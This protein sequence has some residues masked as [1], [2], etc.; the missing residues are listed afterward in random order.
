M[1]SLTRDRNAPPLTR[2]ERPV[3]PRGRWEW[4]DPIEL[5]EAVTSAQTVA[6]TVPLAARWE[7]EPLPASWPPSPV[8]EAD[9]FDEYDVLPSAQFTPGPEYPAQQP[10]RAAPQIQ[11][12]P[13]QRQQPHPQQ[14]PQ[15]QPQRQPQ[16]QSQQHRASLTDTVMHFAQ[17]ASGSTA[18]HQDWA[19]LGPIPAEP[20]RSADPSPSRLSYRLNRLWLT[21]TVRHFV[22]VGLPIMLMVLF[23]GGWLADEGRR[24]SIVE[25][26]VSVRTAVENR[27]Q[28]QVTEITVDSRSPE[29][30]Q[31]VAQLLAISFPISSFQLD[32]PALRA[33]AEALDAVDRASLQVRS[34][35]LEVVIDE[36]LPA[37]VWRNGVGLDLIDGSG[38]RVARL[39]SRAARP[40]L[41]LIA[42]DGAPEAIAE[43]RL[44]W[45]AASPIR[46]RLRGLERVGERRWDVVLDRDQRI[47]LPAN[48]A[49][50]A[51]ER[52]MALNMAQDILARDVQIVDLRNPTRPTLRLSSEAMD[53][54]SRIR[55]ES[56]GAQNR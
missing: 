35:V 16:Q 26:V 27:P 29:V 38:H 15:R 32:L 11:P 53:E 39:A 41:P 20:Q 54:L 10:R 42:G 2:K 48:G 22:R 55:R 34:G 9:R 45:A 23:I 3:D 46:D 8:A 14:Q 19:T 40:D 37:M 51:L 49:L 47:M 52:V 12:R 4:P 44:L 7:C 1:S 43:A 18:I 56:S 36:R 17:S 5:P 33:T 13:V 28:F 30:A 50:G 25:A 21:P 6:A 24:A 31:G